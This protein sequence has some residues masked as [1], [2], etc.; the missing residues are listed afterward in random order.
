MSQ[1]PNAKAVT[2]MPMGDGGRHSG[3]V[4]LPLPGVEVRI[5]GPGGVPLS[6]GE[7]GEVAIGGTRPPRAYLN[8]DARADDR[9][10]DGWLYS[11][12]RLCGRSSRLPAARPQI[13]YRRLGQVA[14][15]TELNQRSQTANSRAR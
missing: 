11:G 7:I 1:T 13:A 8:D 14:P 9:W 3:S 10:M 15:G 4:G 12:G 6:T 2:A 5:V